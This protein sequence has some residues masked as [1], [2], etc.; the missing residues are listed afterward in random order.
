MPGDGI[1]TEIV[2]AFRPVSGDFT[3]ARIHGLT[4]SRRPVALHKWRGVLVCQR[5][6]QNRTSEKLIEIEG[7]IVSVLAGTMFRVELPNGHLVLAHISGKM[8]KRFIRLTGGDRVKLQMSTYD[9]DKARIV[10]RVG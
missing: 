5:M 4:I 9:T 3:L 2:F 8:R 7:K 10:Y 1:V 6:I